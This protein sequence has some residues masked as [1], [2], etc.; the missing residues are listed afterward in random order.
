MSGMV[1][2]KCGHK[3][4]LYGKGGGEKQAKEMDDT[5]GTK[6]FYCRGEGIGYHYHKITSDHF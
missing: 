4:D 3:I 5:R 6:Y 2:P 1:C